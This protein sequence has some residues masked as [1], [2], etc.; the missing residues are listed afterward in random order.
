MNLT[1]M[2]NQ[3]LIK[4]YC[5]KAYDMSYWNAAEGQSWYAEAASRQKCQNEFSKIK[6]ELINRELPIPQGA[7]LV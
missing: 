6:Q 1:D 3:Q 2:N 4:L 7:W 5:D